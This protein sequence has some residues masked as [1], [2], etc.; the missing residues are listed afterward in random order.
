MNIKLHAN[1][2][3]TPKVR[4]YIQQSTQSVAALA[5]E[6]GV[7]ETTIRRWKNRDIAQD[8]S[9]TAHNLQ[10]HLNPVQEWLIV[11]LRKTLLLP[12]DDLLTVVRRF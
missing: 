7:S 11:E 1:A 8:R 4:Q 2:A 10:T 9:H 12:L 3:T 5:K 6:L